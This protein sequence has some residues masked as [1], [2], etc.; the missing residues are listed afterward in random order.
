MK[1]K[2]WAA[3]DEDGKFTGE[4]RPSGSYFLDSK[5]TGWKKVELTI[6]PLTRKKKKK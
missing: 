5:R 2:A 4:I 1:F 3:I 6:K